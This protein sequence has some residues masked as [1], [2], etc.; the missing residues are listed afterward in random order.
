VVQR[1]NADRRE[2]AKRFDPNICLGA[3]QRR[4]A[5]RHRRKALLADISRESAF[6]RLTVYDRLQAIWSPLTAATAF[7]KYM[8]N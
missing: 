2:A 1:Q 6:V 5:G 3:V 7:L 8:K 4:N